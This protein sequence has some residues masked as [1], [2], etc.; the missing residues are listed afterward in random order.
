MS[1]MRTVVPLALVAVGLAG[2]GSEE[3]RISLVP[4]KGTITKN[5]KPLAGATV[6]FL[7]DPGN[8]FNTPGLDST[9]PEG[10]Y[11]I[12]FKNRSGLSPGKYKVLVTPPVNMPGGKVPDA[13]KD[14]PVMAQMAVGVGV[15]GAEPKKQAEEKAEFEAEVGEKPDV[16]DFDVKAKNATPA[17]SK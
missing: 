16:F 7:P 5:G 3:D 12:R 10:T 15:P 6:S 1:W 9:G 2:C 14:D 11:M 13:F 4:V 17:K 8:K